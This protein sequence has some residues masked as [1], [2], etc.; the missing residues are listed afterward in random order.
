MHKKVEVEAVWHRGNNLAERDRDGLRIWACKP[1][2][3]RGASTG[4]LGS[5]RE[6]KLEEA[7]TSGRSTN[8]RREPRLRD[9]E[10]EENKDPRDTE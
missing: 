4:H 8:K 2:S 10:K 5:R 1:S 9:G 7:Q 3:L 6:D